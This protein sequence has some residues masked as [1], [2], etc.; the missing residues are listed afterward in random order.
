M[1]GVHE[2][3]VSYFAFFEDCIA[4]TDFSEALNVEVQ[5]FRFWNQGNREYQPAGTLDAQDYLSLNRAPGDSRCTFEELD[6]E[7]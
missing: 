1:P 2:L 6:H 7:G 4:C 5:D 3:A